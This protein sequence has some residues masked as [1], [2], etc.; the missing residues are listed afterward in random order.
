MFQEP[1][2]LLTEGGTEEDSR[3]STQQSAPV[4]STDTSDVILNTAAD[5]MPD[6]PEP[7]ATK[8]D[9]AGAASAAS[10]P[11]TASLTGA[12][13]RAGE[14]STEERSGQATA[15]LA[16]DQPKSDNLD[17][18]TAGDS[19]EADLTFSEALAQTALGAE[20]S[21]GTSSNTSRSNQSSSDDLTFDQALAATNKTQRITDAIANSTH[22]VVSQIKQADPRVMSPVLESLLPSTESLNGSLHAAVQESDGASNATAANSSDEGTLN[23]THWTGLAGAAVDKAGEALVKTANASTGL[24]DKVC[25]MLSLL[26]IGLAGLACRV[27]CCCLRVICTL[28]ICIL[29]SLQEGQ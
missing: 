14:T 7:N 22:S 15:S 9:G 29:L 21:D 10:E 17:A 11:D 16:A 23:A 24:R 2:Q 8:Y 20:L 13:G 5:P 12:K 3:N 27:G 1:D 18:A 19:Q 4:N 26:I 28:H 25:T 6:I